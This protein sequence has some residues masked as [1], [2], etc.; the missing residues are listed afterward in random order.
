MEVGGALLKRCIVG[1]HGAAPPNETGITSCNVIVVVFYSCKMFERTDCTRKTTVYDDLFKG[2]REVTQGL[3]LLG[4]S[5]VD[6][7]WL[8]CWSS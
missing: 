6:T 2:G 5:D 8:K 7:V 4:R 1:F 3:P